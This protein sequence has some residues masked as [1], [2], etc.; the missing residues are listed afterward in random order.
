MSYDYFFIA[1]CIFIN[2]FIRKGKNKMAV[3]PKEDQVI[4]LYM[5]TGAILVGSANIAGRTVT[6]Y[7]NNDDKDIILYNTDCSDV[8]EGKT[9]LVSKHQIIWI[10]PGGEKNKLE[11]GS[12]YRIRIKTAG[13]HV[14]TGDI[15]ISGYDRISDYLTNFQ[16]DFYELFDC[17]INDKN[18]DFLLISVANSIWKE[19]LS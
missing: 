1:P 15:D 14:L 5:T 13:G 9:L 16:D 11:T 6:E 3:Y 17:T 10:D 7:I 8:S 19:P 12:W 18:Y 2:Y 4:R